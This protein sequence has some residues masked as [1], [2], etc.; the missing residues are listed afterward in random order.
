MYQL[1]CGDCPTVYV[2][3]T[4]RDLH[5]RVTEHEKAVNQNNREKSNFAAHLINTKHSFDRTQNVRLLHAENKGRR[6]TALENIEIVKA[7]NNPKM[8]LCNE[9]IPGSPLAEKYYASSSSSSSSSTA[10]AGEQE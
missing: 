2:G 10:A 7:K 9:I 5:T 1:K 6:L 3:Q 4:G 8:S